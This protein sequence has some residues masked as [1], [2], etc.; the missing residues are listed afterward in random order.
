MTYSIHPEAREEF[1]KA[2]AHYENNQEGLGNKFSDGF[3]AAL[4]RMLIFP[5]A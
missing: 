5:H 3:Y 1:K 4:G 2:Y